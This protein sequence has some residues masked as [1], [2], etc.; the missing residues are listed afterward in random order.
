MLHARI[1]PHISLT[2]FSLLSQICGADWCTAVTGHPEVPGGLVTW[3]CF[4][5]ILCS[6]LQESH[7]NRR[8]RSQIARPFIRNLSVRR[9]PDHREDA[10]RRKPNSVRFEC[11]LKLIS[12]IPI[13]NVHMFIWWEKTLAYECTS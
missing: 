12:I 3:V 5:H 1:M 7:P 13:L 6:H 10:R 4:C 2:W 11:F 8:H 9:V